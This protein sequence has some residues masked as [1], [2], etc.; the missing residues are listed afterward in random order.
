MVFFPSL[1]SHL[2][3]AL[4][5]DWTI[6]IT[7]PLGITENVGVAVTQTSNS[8]VGTLTTRLQNEY[9]LTIDATALTESTK[10]KKESWDTPSKRN[11]DHGIV[12]NVYDNG[13][14]HCSGTYTFDVHGSVVGYFIFFHDRYSR[15]YSKSTPKHTPSKDIHHKAEKG[16]LKKKPE[17]TRM[18]Q[19]ALYRRN[20]KKMGTSATNVLSP[21]NSCMR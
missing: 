12:T 2:N 19:L 18:Q 11:N 5:I 10:T 6:P 4:Y 21:R 1:F 8:G 16:I 7:T 15:C 13:K 17:M 20:K 3:L 14:C 9:T